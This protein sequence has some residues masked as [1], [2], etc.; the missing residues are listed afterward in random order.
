LVNALCHAN[1][2]EPAEAGYRI[3]F[4]E[5]N[6]FLLALKLAA[7][8]APNWPTAAPNVVTLTIELLLDK[9]QAKA[10]QMAEQVATGSGN[11]S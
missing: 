5:L 7:D 9:E 4:D 11:A 3:I 8:G 1:I 10:T 2:L 6:D